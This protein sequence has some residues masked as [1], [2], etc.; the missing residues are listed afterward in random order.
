M[1]SAN[2]RDADLLTALLNGD[3]NPDEDGGRL[4]DL[5]EEFRAD[6]YPLDDILILLR[7]EDAALNRSGAWI[8]SELAAK[9]CALYPCLKGFMS[10]QDPRVRF[11]LLDCI[12]LC[13]DGPGL[14]TIG[15][16]LEDVEPIVRWKALDCLCKVSSS[17]LDRVIEC[18]DEARDGSKIAAG[19]L[20]LRKVIDG[21]LDANAIEERIGRYDYLDRRYVL[22]GLVRGRWTEL[23]M[24]RL[25]E[26]LNDEEIRLFYEDLA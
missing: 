11:H 6:E 13:D 22:A 10:N 4:N 1:I 21:K 7:H 2:N 5:L 26:S 15:R 9:A 18:I 19:F 23:A 17:Q 16:M 14:L 12:L 25:V 20:L 3:W 8:A 24:R